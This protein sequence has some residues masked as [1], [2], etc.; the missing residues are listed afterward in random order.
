MAYSLAHLRALLAVGEW[1]GV[2]RAAAALGVSQPA[3]SK[4]L[5]ALEREAGVPLVVKLPRGMRLTEA[6][7]ALFVHAR[8]ILSAVQA[9]EDDVAGFRGTARGT[10]R[11]AASTTI[12]R[13]IV[14]RLLHEFLRRHPGVNVRLD[15]MHSRFIERL[16]L[17]RQIDVALV[18]TAVHHPRIR[19]IPWMEDRMVIVIGAKHPLARRGRVVPAALTSELLLIREPGSGAHAVAQ[20]A[21]REHGALPARQLIMDDHEAIEQLL[22]L[23]TGIAVMPGSAVADKVRRGSLRIL[24]ADQWDVRRSFFRLALVGRRPSTIGRAFDAVLDASAGMLG[25]RDGDLS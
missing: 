20:A 13:Y 14:P 25:T 4:S 19:L 1:H 23:G 6:G 10:L 7:E 3:V 15:S 8:T 2:S 12:S 22:M 5:R 18:E 9:A 21:L 16:L 11:I 24:A 17:E